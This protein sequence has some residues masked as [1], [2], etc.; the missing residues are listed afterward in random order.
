MLEKNKIISLSSKPI[1]K[2]HVT[3]TKKSILVALGNVN[4]MAK[5]DIKF[6]SCRI[7]NHACAILIHVITTHTKSPQSNV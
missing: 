3:G 5:G 4:V 1:F 2:T 7:S 6:N